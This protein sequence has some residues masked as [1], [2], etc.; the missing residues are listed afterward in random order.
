MLGQTQGKP[1]HGR[2]LD[3]ASAKR[4][5]EL[6]R[7]GTSEGLRKAAQR[8]K[9]SGK[10]QKVLQVPQT[11]MDNATAAMRRAGVPGSVK[12]MGGSKRRS[13]TRK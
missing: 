3:A 9:A 6:E 4:A 2:R 11:H 5:T 12:N 10:V 8:L 1:R 13:V 7:S